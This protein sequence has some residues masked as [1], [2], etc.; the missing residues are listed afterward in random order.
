MKV[1]GLGALKC[2]EAMYALSTTK[3][4]FFSNKDLKS[5]TN[6]G[7]VRIDNLFFDPVENLHLNTKLVG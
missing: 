5:M 6:N 3:G 4:A 1:K 7:K 2:L